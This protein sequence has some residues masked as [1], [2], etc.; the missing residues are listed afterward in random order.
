MA[1]TVVGATGANAAPRAG[2]ASRDETDTAIVR[3]LPKTATLAS[4]K[5]ST[6]RSVSVLG[7]K[8]RLAIV[9]CCV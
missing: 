3:G 4:M 7:V 5:V 1:A 6:I 2:S 8:V 9:F